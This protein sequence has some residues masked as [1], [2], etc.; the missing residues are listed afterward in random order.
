MS[1]PPP[2]LARRLALPLGLSLLAHAGLLAIACLLPALLPAGQPIPETRRMPGFLSIRL[3]GPRANARPAIPRGPEFLEE[4]ETPHI[5]GTPVVWDVHIVPNVPTASASKSGRDGGKPG[6]G[7]SRPG[8]GSTPR[9]PLLAV[10][11]SARRVVYVL[12]RSISMGPSGA[13]ETARREV[14][15][16]LRAL[17]PEARFQVIAYNNVALPLLPGDFVPARPD[18]LAQAERR[19]ADLDAA[20][21]TNHLR[22]LE[23]ALRL[24]PAPEI[25]F[26]LTDAD[27]L[28]DADVRAATRL[29]RGRAVLHVVELTAAPPEG[30]DSPLARLAAANGGSHRRV[31]PRP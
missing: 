22:A 28:D 1:A 9:A 14:L 27:H 19:L 5:K 15:A 23:Q 3:E 21:Q 4:S 10:P 18:K 13:L 29:N 17:P 20:G 31:R 30:T 7:D 11:G 6:G 25:I 2:S 26:L 24:L 8:V 16:S 12:D